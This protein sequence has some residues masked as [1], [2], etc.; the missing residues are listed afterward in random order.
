MRTRS[1]QGAHRVVP[2][3]G[4]SRDNERIGPDLVAARL[5]AS[6]EPAAGVRAPNARRTPGSHDARSQARRFRPTDA[7]ARAA[8]AVVPCADEQRCSRRLWRCFAWRIYGLEPARGVTAG[9][10]KSPSGVA[11]EGQI[12]VN[13]QAPLGAWVTTTATTE[14]TTTEARSE[15]RTEVLLPVRDMRSGR[16]KRRAQGG[17][18]RAHRRGPQV[19]AQKRGT[20]RSVPPDSHNTKGGLRN[21]SRRRPRRAT[22]RVWLP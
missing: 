3:S 7:G 10:K 1:S 13:D 14:A 8:V 4:P 5:S 15:R 12:R 11:P 2:R 20:D 19:R 16:T 6:A 21:D 22:G 9:A 17:V 18:K